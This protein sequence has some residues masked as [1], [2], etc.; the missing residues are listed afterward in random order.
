M[1][2][3][4][5]IAINPSKVYRHPVIGITALG[6]WVPLL[7]S[8]T[9]FYWH[10][11]KTAPKVHTLWKAGPWSTFA[12]HRAAG[13]YTTADL[14]AAAEQA[15]ADVLLTVAPVP[16][17]AAWIDAQLVEYGRAGQTFVG[18]DPRVNLGQWVP[19]VAAP[20]GP[21]PVAGPTP[22]AS[23]SG[24]R[25]LLGIGLLGAGLWLAWR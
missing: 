19:I 9:N 15:L 10:L 7:T 5:V 17:A 18:A 24:S 4:Q 2:A 12:G 21:V 25:V 23:A 20:G 14:T 13:A 3:A 1:A 11:A 16:D 8:A 22:T 6:K